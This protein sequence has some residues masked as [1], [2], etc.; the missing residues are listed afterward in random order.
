MDRGAWSLAWFHPVSA[1]TRHGEYGPSCPS[2]SQ[3]N[4][5]VPHDCPLIDSN[6]LF[7]H[8]LRVHAV[9]KHPMASSSCV[10]FSSS[11]SHGWGSLLREGAAGSPPQALVDTH[12]GSG[13]A[14]RLGVFLSHQ[15]VHLVNGETPCHRRHWMQV[16]SYPYASQCRHLAQPCRRSSLLL[17]LLTRASPVIY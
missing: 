5:I 3:V 16:L 4:L 17:Q 11:S 8:A 14:S 13:K 12:T 1:E 2:H 15:L 9:V 7:A 10:S 6:W